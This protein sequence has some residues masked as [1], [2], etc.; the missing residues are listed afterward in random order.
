MEF[1]ENREEKTGFLVQKSLEME[2]SS[3]TLVNPM[4]S[5]GLFLPMSLSLLIFF[6]CLLLQLLNLFLDYSQVKSWLSKYLLHI[7]L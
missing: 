7:T 2:L 1:I 6:G 5:P 4:Q 3:S